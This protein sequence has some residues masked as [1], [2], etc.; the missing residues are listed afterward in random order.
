[1]KAGALHPIPMDDARMRAADIVEI[2]LK[3]ER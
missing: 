1:V 3:L 2:A